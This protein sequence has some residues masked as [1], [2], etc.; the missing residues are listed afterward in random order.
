[1]ELNP[2]ALGVRLHD[3]FEHKIT[4]V[5]HLIKEDATIREEPISWQEA[6]LFSDLAAYALVRPGAST[7]PPDATIIFKTSDMELVVPCGNWTSIKNML[8]QEVVIADG[9]VTHFMKLLRVTTST[10]FDK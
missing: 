9:V 5:V 4:T 3:L 1:M 2:T 8:A 7:K 6:E 10:T